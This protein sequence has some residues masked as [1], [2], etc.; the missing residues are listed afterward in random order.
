MSKEAMTSGRHNDFVGSDASAGRIPG[1]EK[2]T[3]GHYYNAVFPK[4]PAKAEQHTV[5]AP[6][7]QPRKLEAFMPPPTGRDRPPVHDVG[8]SA[9][10]IRAVQ[11]AELRQKAEQIRAGDDVV[12]DT[13]PWAE[14]TTAGDTMTG[15]TSQDVHK[16][17]GHPGSGMTSK[18]VHH[19]GMGHRKRQGLGTDQHGSANQ[20]PR[21][22][23]PDY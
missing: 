6:E 7:N 4:E 2:A 19:D 9:D 1:A 5:T 20:M 22:E 10:Q 18:E 14:R 8:P 12:V 23:S 17:L 11:A 3:S 15:A 13:D 16:G 21:D